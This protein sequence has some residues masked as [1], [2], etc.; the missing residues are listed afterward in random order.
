MPEFIINLIV[1]GLRSLTLV[2][3][4]FAVAAMLIAAAY[5]AMFLIVA[6]NEAWVRICQACEKIDILVEHAGS[7]MVLAAIAAAKILLELVVTAVVMLAGP[8]CRR[9]YASLT[10]ARQ[11]LRYAYECACSGQHPYADYAAYAAAKAAEAAENAA[12][13]EE[14]KAFRTSGASMKKPDDLPAFERAIAI[15][16]ITADQARDM[17]KVKQRYRELMMIVHPDK[18]F[19]NQLFAQMINEAMD[20][21]KRENGAA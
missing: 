2:G 18:Q 20:I 4:L 7:K 3:W 21:L 5:G 17:R 19:P 14:M 8:A 10:E 15:L 6:G 16:G 13:D 12:T 11:R 9:A 1:G